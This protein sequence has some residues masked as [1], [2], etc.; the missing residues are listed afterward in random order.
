MLFRLAA[1]QV[2]AGVAVGG[3]GL[4]DD[5]LKT[6]LKDVRGEEVDGVG[7]P[8]GRLSTVRTGSALSTQYCTVVSL[9][10][11]YFA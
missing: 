2:E 4:V 1:G 3:N 5:V 9:H 10:R 7:I 8:L 11:Q 6:M